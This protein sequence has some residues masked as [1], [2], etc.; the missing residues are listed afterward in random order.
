MKKLVY[1]IMTVSLVACSGE[2]TEES[3]DNNKKKVEKEV[4]EVD[5]N[6][7]ALGDI[8][9]DL[10]NLGSFINNQENIDKA[11]MLTL[12][13]FQKYPDS[14]ATENTMFQTALNVTN[15]GT[16]DPKKPKKGYLLKAV[17]LWDIIIKNYPNS[18][19]IQRAYENKASIL[20]IYLERDNEAIELYNYLIENY[21]EDTFNVSEYKHRIEHIDE[22]PFDFM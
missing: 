15:F 9:K 8:L 10:Q 20:D 17:D 21:P 22:N 13:M 2:K 3:S 14:T 7:R 11:Y 1:L 4:V 16:S 12:E 6:S 5:E 18:K 19:N